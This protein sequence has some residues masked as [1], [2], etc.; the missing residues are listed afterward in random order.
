MSMEECEDWMQEK[1]L[2]R[3]TEEIARRDDKSGDGQKESALDTGTNE[4]GFQMRS[5]WKV[6]PCC[7]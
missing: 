3:D 6:C 4:Q 7:M 5:E 2:E 1:A